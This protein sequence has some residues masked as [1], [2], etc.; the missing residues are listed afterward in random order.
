MAVADT[1]RSVP[2]EQF[3]TDTVRPHSAG[4]RMPTITYFAG[5]VKGINQRRFAGRPAAIA[6]D[7]CRAIC[8]F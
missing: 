2:D 5:A 4:A 7:K 6:F 1:T 3:L 8:Y